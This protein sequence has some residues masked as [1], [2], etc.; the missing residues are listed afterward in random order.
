MLRI[1]LVK[2]DGQSWK[3]LFPH[4]EEMAPMEAIRQVC[5]DPEPASHGYMDL[6]PEGRE[7]VDLHR[8]YRHAM[9]TGEL[10]YARELEEE[11]QMMR[12]NVRCRS[13]PARRLPP[14]HPPPFSRRVARQWG[15]EKA[16]MEA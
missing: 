1:M 16:H 5:E 13:S 7:L 11:M 8:T 6:S 4:E 15:K 9:A 3:K 10:D 2:S 12:F 14:A